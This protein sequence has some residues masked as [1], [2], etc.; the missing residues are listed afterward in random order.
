MKSIAKYGKY[1][2]SLQYFSSLQ[3]DIARNSDD[4]HVDFQYYYESNNESCDAVKTIVI[5]R[6]Y[7][8]QESIAILCNIFILN[9]FIIIWI[10]KI[11]M[12]GACIIANGRK[13]R[14]FSKGLM[15]SARYVRFSF[16]IPEGGM[17]SGNLVGKVL[18]EKTLVF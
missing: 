2:N 18:R 16:P 15:Y 17:Y 7:W 13:G 12:R 11:K 9:T 14:L 8:N 1:C 6:K 3:D 5:L 10:R 4:S